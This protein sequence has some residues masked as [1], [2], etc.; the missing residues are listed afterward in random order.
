MTF[1]RCPICHTLFRVTAEQLEARGGRVR[2]GQCANVFN[3][4][5]HPGEMEAGAAAVPVREEVAPEDFGQEALPAVLVSNRREAMPA[6]EEVLPVVH[7]SDERVEPVIRSE[8]DE[9]A[10]M[11]PFAVDWKEDAA[12]SANEF[13]PSVPPPRPATAWPWVTAMALLGFLA[14]LQAAWVFRADLAMAYPELRPG[15][16]AWCEDLGCDMPLPRESVQIGIEASDLRPAR[17]GLLKL[18][19]T[20]RNRAAFPQAFPDLELTLTDTDDKALAR[21]VF[22]PKDFLPAKAD[23]NA[24]F[25][26][27]GDLPISLTLDTT[28][29]AAAGYRLYVFYP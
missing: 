21:R 27:N 2:C 10:P 18:S 26:A 15:F 13:V 25:A 28:P 16:V 23:P 12:A 5:E 1:T 3:A 11:A 6:Q 8:L 14:L 17:E 24:G 4:L 7:G 20:L 19:A 29:I 9:S 22:T